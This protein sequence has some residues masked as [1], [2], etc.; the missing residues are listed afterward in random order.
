MVQTIKASADTGAGKSAGA[1]VSVFVI[2]CGGRADFGC[3]GSVRRR[4]GN[5][6]SGG[7]HGDGHPLRH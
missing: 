3:G 2:G 5:G 6:V 7:K 1:G 4:C